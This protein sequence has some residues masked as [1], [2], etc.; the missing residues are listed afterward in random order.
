MLAE[1]RVPVAPH[2]GVKHAS[3]VHPILHSVARHRHV[4]VGQVEPPRGARS[5][6]VIAYREVAVAIRI[7]ARRS[8]MCRVDNVV[9]DELKLVSC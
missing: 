3:H 6:D 5:L 9:V 8:N 1:R 4:H 7:T 2:G